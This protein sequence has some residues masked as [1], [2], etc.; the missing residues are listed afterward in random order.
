MIQ[1]KPRVN[2]ETGWVGSRIDSLRPTPSSLVNS[3]Q[4][5]HPK[6]IILFLTRSMA[7]LTSPTLAKTLAFKHSL[8]SSFLS[9]HNAQHTQHPYC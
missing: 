6:L 7:S 9:Q 4:L 8:P 1:A 3:L 5:F 2:L